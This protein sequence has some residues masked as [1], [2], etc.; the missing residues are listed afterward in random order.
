MTG[1][2][3][4]RVGVGTRVIRHGQLFK[5][6]EI[7]AGGPAGAEVVLCSDGVPPQYLRLSMRAPATDCDG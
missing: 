1:G 2:A 6:V 7:H 4:I 5:V 3:H